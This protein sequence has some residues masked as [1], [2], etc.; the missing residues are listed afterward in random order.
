MLWWYHS[1]LHRFLRCTGAAQKEKVYLSL[2]SSRYPAV[3]PDSFLRLPSF[4]AANEIRHVFFFPE[5]EKALQPVAASNFVQAVAHACHVEAL[6]DL[7]L[8][9]APKLLPGQM[10]AL[11]Y[12]AVFH[13]LQPST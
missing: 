9:K 6:T 2:E 5:K 12:P 4:G 1:T 7:N 13:S 10:N 3:A 11:L 8:V